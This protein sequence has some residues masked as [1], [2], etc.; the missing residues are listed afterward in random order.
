MVKSIHPA[1]FPIGDRN[2]QTN[3]ALLCQLP[4][5]SHGYFGQLRGRS[6]DRVARS[7]IP[8]LKRSLFFGANINGYSRWGWLRENKGDTHLTSAVQHGNLD[9]VDFLLSR[10]AN[11]NHCDA[12]GMPP[13]C[14]A[15]I[16]G[17]LHVS[18]ALVDGGA[19]PELPDFDFHGKPEKTAFDYARTEGRNVHAAYL[20]GSEQ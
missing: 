4:A 2:L 8:S 12:S 9:T 1:L 3:R 19:K 10:G 7:D 17:R 20:R 15:A 18:K 13:T 16:F 5:Y 11:P 6:W 14:W